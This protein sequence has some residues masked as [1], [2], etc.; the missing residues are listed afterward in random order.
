[1]RNLKLVEKPSLYEADFYAWIHE[2]TDLLKQRKHTAF[3]YDNL[4][5]EISSM[6][7]EL[8]HALTSSYRLVMLHLLKWQFQPQFRGASWEITISRERDN[9]ESREEDKPSLKAKASDFVAKAYVRARRSAA[10][11]TGLPLSTFPEICPYTL[12]QLRDFDWMPS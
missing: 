6:G 7:N 11:E 5:E 2:Q 3:D 1:M 9:I 8:E 10:K 4:I 12:D